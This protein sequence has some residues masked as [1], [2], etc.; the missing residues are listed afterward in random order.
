MSMKFSEN[1][2]DIAICAH[3]YEHV[4][5]AE[6]LMA[7]IYRVLKPR[8][9]CYFA[10]GNRLNVKE[11]HYNL[12]FLSILPRS[13]AHVYIR[14]SGKNKFY[15]EK[16]LSYWGLKRLVQ[17]FERID[18]TQKIIESPEEFHA[19]YLIS[20]DTKKG[21]LARLIVKYAYWLSPTYIWLLRKPQ[22]SMP[23]MKC[24]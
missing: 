6:R 18:Y 24:P 3:I 23:E 1:I 17:K 11:P 16:H 21:K 7:E 20:P 13:L 22:Q 9:V 4:P 10:A 14:T 5:D 12:P 8:G 2:F 19:E 15:Y